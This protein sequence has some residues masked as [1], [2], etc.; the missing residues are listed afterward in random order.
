MPHQN[1]PK[2]FHFDV[3]YRQNLRGHDYEFLKRLDFENIATARAERNR[4]LGS[5]GELAGKGAYDIDV[6]DIDGPDVI[7][8]YDPLARQHVSEAVASLSLRAPDGEAIF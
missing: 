5:R 1:D 3:F 8:H 4:M 7:H 6:S 2:P